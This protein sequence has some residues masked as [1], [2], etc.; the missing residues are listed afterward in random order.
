MQIQATAYDEF[1][2]LGNR[3][4]T[5]SDV[6]IWRYDH[7]LKRLWKFKYQWQIFIL[8]IVFVMVESKSLPPAL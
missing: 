4:D 1:T 5:L 7:E 2:Y 6:V 8:D 3:C